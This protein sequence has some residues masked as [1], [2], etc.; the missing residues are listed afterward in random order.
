MS[1]PIVPIDLTR[2]PPRS[3]RGRLVGFVLLLRILD[4]GRAKLAGKN[5]EYNYNPAYRPTPRQ[6]PR[7]RSRSGFEGAGD[8]ERRR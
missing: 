3:M 6:V 8:R 2:R 4:K 1:T 5:V 7:A